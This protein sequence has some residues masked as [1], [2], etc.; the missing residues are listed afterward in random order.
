M[1]T[2]VTVSPGDAKIR[3]NLGRPL[4]DSHGRQ[5]A[6]PGWA[7]GIKL[8][9]VFCGRKWFVIQTDSM[10]QDRHGRRTGR[11]WFAFDIEHK[12]DQDVIANICDRLGI[13]RPK[14]VG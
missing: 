1:K 5:V 9:A 8:E 7:T 3:L 10:W 12:F 4:V 2:T 11:G 14:R 6:D 13:E